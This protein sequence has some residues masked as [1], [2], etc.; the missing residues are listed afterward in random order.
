[1]AE[2]EIRENAPEEGERPEY[3][4]SFARVE[5]LVKELESGDLS[6]K[7]SI[8][9]YEEATKSM[10]HCYQLLEEAQKKIEL[11]VKDSEGVITGRQDFKAE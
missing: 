1:M 6:L 8:Q 2:E 11:L 3:E 5:E 4:E 9:K 7:E 10:N